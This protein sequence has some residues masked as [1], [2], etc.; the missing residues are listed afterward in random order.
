MPVPRWA[1]STN[2]SSRKMLGRQLEGVDR[3]VEQRQAD[4]AGRRPPPGWRARAGGG[5]T[6]RP[7]KSA[8]VAVTSCSKLFVFGQ[9]ADETQDVRDIG[10]S[11]AERR[12]GG[13]TRH[14]HVMAVPRPASGVAPVGGASR[15]LAHADGQASP[16]ITSRR[17]RDAVCRR[18]QR[19]ARRCKHVGPI[20]DCRRDM[21]DPMPHPDMPSQ[22]MYRAST[23]PA[24]YSADPASIPSRMP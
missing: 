24:A 3:V 2:R 4:G 10:R 9:A 16:A 5:R 20:R 18:E 17:A 13:R 12:G 21:V 1:G 22:R 7:C 15:G 6:G 8:S 14:R 19:L 23:K 11:R